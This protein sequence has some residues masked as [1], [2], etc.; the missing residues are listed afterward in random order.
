MIP[1]S[2]NSGGYSN[3]P[4]RIPIRECSGLNPC[5]TKVNFNYGDITALFPAVINSVN[6]MYI[7]LSFHYPNLPTVKI[8]DSVFADFIL[9]D[10]CAVL[11]CI[12]FYDVII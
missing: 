2:R 4:Q 12:A 3:S 9:C 6:V 10:Y 8:D 5:D 1:K 11:Y 7:V